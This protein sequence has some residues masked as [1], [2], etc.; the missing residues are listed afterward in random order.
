MKAERW[1]QIEQ[2]YHSALE[3]G[4]EAAAEFQK[5]LDHRGYA[6]LSPLYPLAHLG[7]ARAAALTGDRAKSQKA[8]ED[9][10]A[11]WKEADE[12]LPIL[13]AARREHEQLR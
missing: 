6:P 13:R 10:F 7:L 4:A 11:V 1:Q 5:I 2:L 12:E 3:R 9:F 8:W